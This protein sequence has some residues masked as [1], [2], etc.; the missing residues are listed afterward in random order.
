MAVVYISEYTEGSQFAP[1]LGNEPA[2]TQQTVAITAGSV[3]SSAFG[4]NTTVVRVHT[5]A[6]CSY[7]FGTNPTASATTARMAAGQT[8]YFKVLP[9]DK[10]AVITNT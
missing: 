5:D 6:I 7:R 2:V 10:V 3:Q 4:R 1:T 8:E 9:G